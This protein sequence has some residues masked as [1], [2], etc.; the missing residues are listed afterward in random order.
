MIE[1]NISGIWIKKEAIAALLEGTEAFLIR[2]FEIGHYLHI[3]ANRKTL[4]VKDLQ[5]IPILSRLFGDPAY[6]EPKRTKD[7]EN[8]MATGNEDEILE[9][10]TEQQNNNSMQTSSI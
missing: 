2:Y 7:G 6:Q 5:L 4:M 10:G 8:A 9:A 1:Q 3:H